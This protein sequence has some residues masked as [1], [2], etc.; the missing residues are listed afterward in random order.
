M[1]AHTQDI[2]DARNEAELRILTEIF[3]LAS[4]A[5]EVGDGLSPEARQQLPNDKV[6]G[7]QAR[8]GEEWAR[9]RHN[10]LREEFIGINAKYRE[11]LAER[12][13]EILEALFGP[14]EEADPGRILEFGAASE[15]TL[16]TVLEMAIAADNLAAVQLVMLAAYERQLGGILDVIGEKVEGFDDLLG[17]LFTLDNVPDSD[18][19]GVR[20]SA[21]ASD[22]PSLQKILTK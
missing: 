22:P 2:I 3:E 16:T 11:A 21:L 9:N 10:E 1:A 8:A 20:F 4:K 13:E 18:E 7:L 15:A 17:E 14:S 19:A 6:R 5:K 12:R